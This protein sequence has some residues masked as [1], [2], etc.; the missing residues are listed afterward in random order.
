MWLIIMAIRNALLPFRKD[1]SDLLELRQVAHKVLTFAKRLAPI[2]ALPPHITSI[3]CAAADFMYGNSAETMQA[4]TRITMQQLLQIDWSLH[5]SVDSGYTV[6][7]DKCT[8][9]RAMMEAIHATDVDAVVAAMQPAGGAGETTTVGP[10]VITGSGLAFLRAA[11][12]HDIVVLH[13]FLQ[14]LI[15]A[16]ET[17]TSPVA[18]A[19]AAT[20]ITQTLECVHCILDIMSGIPAA[21][22]SKEI[23]SRPPVQFVRLLRQFDVSNVTLDDAERVASCPLAG[24]TAAVHAEVISLRKQCDAASARATQAESKAAQMQRQLTAALNIICSDGGGGD[25]GGAR[26]K[27]D[28]IQAKL[29]AT[30]AKLDAVTTELRRINPD[31]NVLK[32]LPRTKRGPHAMNVGDGNGRKKSARR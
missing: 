26:A 22:G 7:S 16:I 5:Q 30:Q 12:P 27:L 4:A 29:D 6:P 11:W 17:S 14:R 20:P 2:P 1:S 18:A 13:M 23:L 24:L 31:A 28:A 8:D 21:T 10:A 19:S 9:V 3:I 15:Q 25:G 32:T